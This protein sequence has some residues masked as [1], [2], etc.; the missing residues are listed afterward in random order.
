MTDGLT[1]YV[2]VIPLFC[3]PVRP[4]SMHARRKSVS[5]PS[6]APYA[7]PGNNASSAVVQQ[8]SAKLDAALATLNDPDIR[9]VA[10]EWQNTELATLYKLT[11]KSLER[12]DAVRA[13]VAA[14]GPG[15][16][17]D[18]GHVKM[19]GRYMSQTVERDT[20]VVHVAA[21]LRTIPFREFARGLAVAT[22]VI[23]GVAY[24]FYVVYC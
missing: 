22:S 16:S 6:L 12:E 10:G 19:S 14:L 23:T 9:T 5:S 21:G 15:W 17:V 24:L 11:P 2:P 20:L 1:N 8:W 4:T 3:L 7:L 18:Y 13:A